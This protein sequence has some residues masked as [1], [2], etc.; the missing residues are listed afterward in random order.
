MPF[1]PVKFEP[2]YDDDPSEY[3]NLPTDW[4]HPADCPAC[5]DYAAVNDRINVWADNQ[6]LVGPPPFGP[7][8]LVWRRFPTRFEALR[9]HRQAVH[10]AHRAG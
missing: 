3:T 10:R 4:P 7:P 5:G 1:I 2:F 6:H 8:H 9:K